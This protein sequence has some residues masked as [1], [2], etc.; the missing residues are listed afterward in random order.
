NMMPAIIGI[1]VVVIGIGAFLLFRGK[2][3]TT[4]PATTTA[5]PV[6]AAPSSNTTTAGTTSVTTSAASTTAAP[7]TTSLDQAKIDAEVKKRLD[8]ERLKL[9]QQNKTPQQAAQTAAA[10]APVVSRPTP[11]PA[12]AQTAQTNT[13]APAP[14]PVP[15]A[16]A[17]QPVVESRPAPAPQPAAA[18]APRV[19]EGDLVPPGTEGLNPARMLHQAIPLYPAIARAQRVEGTVIVNVLISETGRVL[20][21][22]VLSGV[23]RPVGINEAA[24][25]TVRN[26]TFAPGTKEGVR[27]KSWTTVVVAFKL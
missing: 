11:A 15:V 4:A 25:Q 6:A 2:G 8:A 18:E 19:R 20:D 24:L 14:A 5:K 26:S 16:P 1:V 22:K 10:A 13:I 7:T 3:N 17:P 23:N 12:P 21:A 27:V 9:E